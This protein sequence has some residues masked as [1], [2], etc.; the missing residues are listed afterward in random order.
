ME[1][2]GEVL[3]DTFYKGH[4]YS[5]QFYVVDHPATQSILGLKSCEQLNLIYRV[6]EM[7]ESQITTDSIFDKYE[8]VIS[9]T[10]IACL[11]VQH[12]IEIDESAKPVVHPPRNVP[13]ALRPKINAELDRMEQMGVILSVTCPTELVSSLVTVAKP[14]KLRL[15]IDPKNLNEAVKREHYPMKTIESVLTRLPEANFSFNT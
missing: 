14:D 13:A 3:L 9:M 2:E 5:W 8:D 1:V 6:E 4:K 10:T 12:H 7:C 11:P 15:C